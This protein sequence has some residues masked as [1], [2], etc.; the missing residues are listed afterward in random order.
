VTDLLA[1]LIPTAVAGAINVVPITV[2]ATLLATRGGVAKATGFAVGLI[3][4]FAI[5]G[6]IALA[7]VSPDAGSSDTGS[8][9]TGTIV[10]TLG[11]LL[12]LFAVKQL[13]G[14]PDPDAPPPGYMAKLESMSVSGALVTGVVLGALNIKQVAIYVG[15]IAEIVDAD[16]SSGEGW[17]ALALLLVLIQLGVILPILAFLLAREWTTTALVAL[18]GWLTR[19][20]RR[21]SIVIGLVVGVWFVI[22]GVVLIAG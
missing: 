20:N 11:V 9:V 10:A 17:V 21:I 19:H 13:L 8:A 1:K 5:I 12:L 7:T 15:G 4:T 3:G 2:V 16:V 18:R 22:E 14:A 6:A